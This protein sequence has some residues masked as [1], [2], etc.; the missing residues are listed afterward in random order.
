MKTSRMTP[1][2]KAWVAKLQAVIA[3][4]PSKRLAAYTVGDADITLYDGSKQ[5]QILAIQDAKPSM[6]FGNCV[7]DADAAL[8]HVAFPFQIHSVAG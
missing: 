6:E 1:A 4:C 7:E 8:A 3:E 5:D 2:E